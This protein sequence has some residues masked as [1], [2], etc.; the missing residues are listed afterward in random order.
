MLFGFA[1]A[2]ISGFLLTALPG[3]AGTPEIHGG[4]LAFLSLLW[5]LGRIVFWLAPLLPFALVAIVDSSLFLF[6][7]F[8]LI[9]GL[10]GAKSKLYWVLVPI[11]LWFFGCDVAFYSG[12][13]KGDSLAVDQALLAKVYGLIFLYT[14]VAGILVPSFTETALKQKGWRGQMT[15]L[16]WLEWAAVGTAFLYGL[17]GLFFIGSDIAAWAALLALGVHSIRFFRW[18]G[19]KVADTPIVFILHV[20][21][22]WLLVAFLLR[23]LSDLGY[24]I[25]AMSSIHAYTIGALGLMKLG[26]MTR[27]ALKHTGRSLTPNSLVVSAYGLMFFAA[28]IRLYA[29]FSMIEPF[30]IGL[31]S[32]AWA[33]AF[34]I[35]FFSYGK[36]FLVPS[37]PR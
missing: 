23:A 6:M 13:A 1:G 35:Y 31:S 7:V 16:P 8:L 5:L 28:C 12:L 22:G 26:L 4:R 33:L 19:L 18:Q 14:I 2:I 37:L 24:A 17:S 36:L 25:P 10:K 21:Y 27:V 32:V 30:M 3:W 20:G 9:P 29:P 11:L 15:L 34:A